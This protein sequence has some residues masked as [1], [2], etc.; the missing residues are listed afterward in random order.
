MGK[1]YSNIGAFYS[2][3]T[4]N[5]GAQA[6]QSPS[7]NL[8]MH[9]LCLAPTPN[10]RNMQILLDQTGR[11]QAIHRTKNLLS[12]SA[13]ETENATHILHGLWSTVL[14]LNNLELLFQKVIANNWAGFVLVEVQPFSQ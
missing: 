1:I 10:L 13:K 5:L 2:A 14:R 8:L 6:N 9:I 7:I 4:T 3:H 12:I 11:H